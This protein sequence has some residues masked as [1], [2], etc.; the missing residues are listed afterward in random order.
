MLIVL[1]GCDGSGK[2]TL[3]DLLKNLA[4][5]PD[6]IEVIHATRETPN[7]MDWFMSVMDRARN[8][9]IIMDRAFWGQFVYQ[10]PSERKLGFND[11]SKLECRLAA[12]GGKL[13]YVYSPERVIARRLRLR[14]ETPS[15]PIKSLLRRYKTMCEYAKCPVIFYNSHNGKCKPFETHKL[16]VVKEGKK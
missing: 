5:N 2:S 11:L 4:H 14:N 7:D 9:N 1:E 15:L 10:K 13:I 16:K 12:D 8:H 3:V 6:D